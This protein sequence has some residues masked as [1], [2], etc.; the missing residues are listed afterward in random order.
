MITLRGLKVGGGNIV[1]GRGPVMIYESGINGDGLVHPFHRKPVISPLCGDQPQ[2]M[3][4][5]R[6]RRITL[7]DLFVQAARFLCFTTLVE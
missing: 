2:K 3:Q 1:Y 5:I 7:N 4:G 6:M